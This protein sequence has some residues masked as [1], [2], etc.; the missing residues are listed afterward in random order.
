MR[1]SVPLGRQT[2]ATT[3][4]AVARRVSSAAAGG[5]RRIASF[6]VAFNQG[7]QARS[8]GVGVFPPS[9]ASTSACALDI[10]SGC[11]AMSRAHHVKAVAV[12]SCPAWKVEMH[13]STISR[14][15]SAAPSASG[16]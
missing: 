14:R 16:P 9:A 11:S 12:V 15:V 5:Y 1:N 8:S 6:K 2:P 3:M 13:W 4:S 10:A 7:M